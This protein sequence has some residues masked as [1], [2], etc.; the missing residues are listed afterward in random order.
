MHKF[1]LDLRYAHRDFCIKYL[2]VLID[3]NLSWKPLVEMIGKKSQKEHW[4]VM[5]AA[6][7]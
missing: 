7:H 2:S 5:K 3:S 4:N 1:F 6:I